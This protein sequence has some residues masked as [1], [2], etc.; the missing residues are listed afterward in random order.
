MG[1]VFEA[2][3]EETATTTPLK[4]ASQDV[5]LDHS[6]G[7]NVDAGFKVRYD[8][9]VV[10]VTK[11]MD[12]AGNITI[13]FVNSNTGKLVSDREWTFNT[14]DITIAYRHSPS[15]LPSAVQ[16]NDGYQV[17][18]FMLRRDAFKD[19]NLVADANAAEVNPIHKYPRTA[20]D[21]AALAQRLVRLKNQILALLELPGV[22]GQLKLAEKKKIQE[23][24]EGGM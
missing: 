1:L 20:S 9:Y 2:E 14:N 18:F 6:I 10:L 15:T 12:T 13:K 16:Y 24:L 11:P 23:L 17:S 4:R 8:P 3:N 5:I 19:A 7:F 22:E 21:N